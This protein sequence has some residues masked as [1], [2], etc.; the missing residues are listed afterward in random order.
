MVNKHDNRAGRGTAKTAR[1][2]LHN[3]EAVVTGGDVQQRVALAGQRLAQVQ[4]FL[5]THG[6]ETSCGLQCCGASDAA[7]LLNEADCHTQRI[8]NLIHSLQ[9]ATSPHEQSTAKARRD[10]RSVHRAVPVIA[11][12]KQPPQGASYILRGR[13]TAEPGRQD[14]RRLSFR[15]RAKRPKRSICSHCEL[16]GPCTDPNALMTV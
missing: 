8:Q 13:P 14:V 4:L 7:H 1:A 6:N 10:R 16:T 12:R 3:G 9:S 15:I 5:A 2:N 11:A